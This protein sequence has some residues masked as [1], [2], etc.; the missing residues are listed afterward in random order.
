MGRLCVE[1]QSLRA[2]LMI[3]L[4]HIQCVMPACTVQ[5]SVCC[6]R[7]IYKH[8]M[9]KVV[10]LPIGVRGS[11]QRPPCNGASKAC[12]QYK[13]CYPK[14]P[15]PRTP[16]VILNTRC[17]CRRNSL[18]ILHSNRVSLCT[19]DAPSMTCACDALNDTHRGLRDRSCAVSVRS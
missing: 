9:H 11:K 14:G 16:L 18:H 15:A 2:G 3:V 8:H 17:R 13:P 6:A 7:D 5:I 1:V 19:H 4:Q 12:C 10:D